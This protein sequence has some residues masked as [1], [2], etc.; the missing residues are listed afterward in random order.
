MTTPTTA[1]EAREVLDG[2]VDDVIS[3]ARS[4][5]TGGAGNTDW[6]RE[7]YVKA[8]DAYAFAVHVEVCGIVKADGSVMRATYWG[9]G[10]GYDCKIAEKYKIGKEQ[11]DK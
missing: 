4:I 3:Q 7:E 11:H 9:C 1:E 6:E 8:L 2:T 10:D 5:A